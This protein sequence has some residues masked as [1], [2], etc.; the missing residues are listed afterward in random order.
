LDLPW[1]EVTTDSFDLKQARDVLDRDHFG[2]ESKRK[3]Y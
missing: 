1:D 2:L 3:N